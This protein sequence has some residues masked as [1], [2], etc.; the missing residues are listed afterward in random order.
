[1]ILFCWSD[2]EEAI[3]DLLLD[4]VNLVDALEISEP[5]ETLLPLR[6]V[7]I[8]SD[9]ILPMLPDPVTAAEELVQPI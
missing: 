1:M 5:L 8:L 6:L 7:F 2:I 3:E 9:L 4:V